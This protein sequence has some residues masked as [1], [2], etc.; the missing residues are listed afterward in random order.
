MRKVILTEEQFKKF[1]KEKLSEASSNGIN[2]AKPGWDKEFFDSLTQ[3]EGNEEWDTAK[4][5]EAD[6]LATDLKFALDKLTD[7]T[8]TYYKEAEL[9]A[10]ALEICNKILQILNNA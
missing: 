7:P 8:A 2:M 6:S 4:Y 3:T 9:K 5:D 10:E 1:I